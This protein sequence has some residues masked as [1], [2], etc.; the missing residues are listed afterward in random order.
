MF[1]RFTPAYFKTW[2]CLF[3]FLVPQQ[4]QLNVQAKPFTQQTTVDHKQTGT[5][6]TQNSG[7][8]TRY[9]NLK[10]NGRRN[11]K[12]S[13]VESSDDPFDGEDW[14]VNDNDKRT[15]IETP[16]APLSDATIPSHS[17]E[18]GDSNV[19]SKV[20]SQVNGGSVEVRNQ[21]TTSQDTS[22]HPSSVA[23]PTSDST[24]Q[25][26]TNGV[27]T[28]NKQKEVNGE[29][30]LGNEKQGNTAVVGNST[31]E[32]P[33][34]KTL[35]V[36]SN[37]KVSE[38][39]SN[40][41]SSLVVRGDIKQGEADSK[42]NQNKSD[43]NYVSVE[44]SIVNDQDKTVQEGAKNVQSQ[45][46]NML[47]NTQPAP[48]SPSVNQP[49]QS[50]SNR[51]N[52]PNH[53]NAT[54][55]AQSEPVKDA[56]GNSGKEIVTT[57]KLPYSDERLT[58]R[59]KD[60]EASSANS[61]GSEIG[62]FQVDDKSA[63]LEINANSAGVKVKAKPASLQVVSRP[64]A[65]PPPAV[66]PFAPAYHHPWHHHWLPGFRR[67]FPYR[68]HHLRRHYGAPYGGYHR[69]WMPQRHR[70]FYDEMPYRR[71]FRPH[72]YHHY[73]CVD[74]LAWCGSV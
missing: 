10:E 11:V 18:A 15:G 23:S 37:G 43:K 55:S 8:W 63:D 69:S 48:A 40:A 49:Q 68:R 7:Q 31:L 57:Q 71:H 22:E 30:S 28:E 2:V 1:G 5:I 60:G 4:Q 51:D 50:R 58:T 47:K 17:D 13:T 27:I 52:E 6:E 16:I 19:R 29:N 73:R 25:Q 66:V 32:S 64:G 54:P 56:V 61:A 41:E 65:H 36:N 70:Y 20:A 45:P 53:E 35:S 38:P 39:L 12:R 9:I 72:W 3:S 46:D 33:S 26:V 62:H 34:G 44:N 24:A 14:K 21:G 67:G 59:N 74:G 42:E